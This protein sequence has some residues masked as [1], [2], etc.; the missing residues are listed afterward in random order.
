MEKLAG[1]LW[2]Y[3][4]LEGIKFGYHLGWDLYLGMY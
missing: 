3:V 2:A 1:A 4:I